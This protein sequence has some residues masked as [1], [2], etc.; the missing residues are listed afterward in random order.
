[1]SVDPWNSALLELGGAATPQLRTEAIDRLTA[2]LEQSDWTLPEGRGTEIAAALRDRLSDNNWSVTQRCLLLVGDL[3]AEL[4]PEVCDC[5][6]D[7]R[8]S[9]V[10]RRPFTPHIYFYLVARRRLMTLSVLSCCPAS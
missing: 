1:M 3:V 10:A 7:G 4:D 9:S 5:A 6:A 8:A 2:L